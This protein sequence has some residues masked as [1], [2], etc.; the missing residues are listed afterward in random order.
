M[1]ASRRFTAVLMACWLLPALA[2][3]R[4]A[5]TVADFV[6]STGRNKGDK[7]R[8]ELVKALQEADAL[9]LIPFSKVRTIAAGR[10]LRAADLAK[11]RILGR[12]TQAAGADAAVAGILTRVGSEYRLAVHVY[13]LEGAEI[14]SKAVP[15]PG[16]ELSPTVA[17]R[18]ANAVSAAVGAKAATVAEAP[19]PEPKPEPEPDPE[20]EPAP[21]PKSKPPEDAP[22]TVSATPARNDE[23]ESP[24]SE[25]PR[26]KTQRM[27]PADEEPSIEEHDEATEA[28]DDDLARPG[29][30]EFSAD[31]TLTWRNYQFCP[32]VEDCSQTPP[33]GSGAPVKYTTNSPYGGFYLRADVF[34]LRFLDNFGRGLGLS[35]AFGRSVGLVTHYKKEDGSPDSFESTQQRLQFAL[36]YRFYFRLDGI[37]DGWV[38]LRGGYLMHGFFVGTNPKIVESVRAG[39]YGELDV[40]MPLQ[41]FI[42]IEARAALVPLAGPGATEK[43]KYGAGD[44]VSGR[45]TNGGGWFMEAG[46]TSDLGHPEWH[47]GL[48][49]MFEYAWFGDRYNNPE[50]VRPVF[51][52][53]LE[54]YLGLR[55]GLKTQF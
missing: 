12:M 30:V 22:R 35:A 8:G 44:P 27:K 32:E 13:D 23:P 42:R 28:K 11:P 31:F 16:G 50:D 29:W 54:S 3:A 1:S 21:K 4:P 14:W 20:P 9:D 24:V 15:L 36:A 49:A 41:R 47:I 34:P 48:Q 25:P 51:G 38:G 39:A 40:A 55:L 37:G 18:F 5:V 46:L 45:E 2:V 7:A 17:G 43:A 33:V 10:K 6:D 52:R 19:K 53:A 26:R